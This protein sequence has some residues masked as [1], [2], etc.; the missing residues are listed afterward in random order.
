[1]RYWVCQSCKYGCVDVTKP[2]KC[3]N[4]GEVGG[5]WKSSDVTKMGSFKS[6][7]CTNCERVVEERRPPTYPCD[8]CGQRS[9]KIFNAY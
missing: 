3:N 8:V 9:W 2:T 1:M 7:M 4:C 5:A 6:Y